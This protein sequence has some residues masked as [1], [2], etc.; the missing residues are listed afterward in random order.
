MYAVLE[1]HLG[2][3][4]DRCQAAKARVFLLGYPF[5]LPEHERIVRR[6]A[7]ARG[8]PFVS[9]VGAFVERL[10][11]TSRAELFADEIHCTALGY[12]LVARVACERLADELR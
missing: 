8:V 9:M 6:V 2:I 5:A 3:A 12:D 4:I 1:R 10:A 11:N 7:E